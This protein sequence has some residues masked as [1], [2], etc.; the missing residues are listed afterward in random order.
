MT[1]VS[2]NYHQKNYRQL[3]S[4]RYR[5]L[6]AVIVKYRLVRTEPKC[7][8]RTLIRQKCKYSQT[9]FHCCFEHSV[10]EVTFE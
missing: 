7:M 8:F 5:Q 1:S 4:K 10:L 3:S 2:K 6:S 9:F